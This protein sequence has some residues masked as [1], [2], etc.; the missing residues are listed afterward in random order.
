MNTHS[1]LRE[2][3]KSIR[4]QN[5]FTA[6][7]EQPGIHLFKNVCEFSALQETF[8]ILLYNYSV[9]ND[10]IHLHKISQLTLEKDIYADA[11]LFWKKTKGFKQFDSVAAERDVSLVAGNHI[12]FP[13]R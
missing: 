11:Y 12:T 5:I 1:A 2:L 9:I 13:K 4:F 3:A 7:K 6:S 10:D 8:L